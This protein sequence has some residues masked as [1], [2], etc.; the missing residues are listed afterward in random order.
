MQVFQSILVP[1]DGSVRAEQAIP[2]AARVA[3]ASGG[4]ITLLRV[5]SSTELLPYIFGALEPS[6]YSADV[7]T[8]NVYLQ[9]VAQGADLAD[10]TVRTEV[11]TGLAASMILERARANHADL[12]VMTSHGHSGLV[13]WALGSVASKVAR[14]SEEP[15]LVIREEA[16]LPAAPPADSPL[17]AL[18]ALDGSPTAEA[19]LVPAMQLIG[20]MAGSA[21][22]QLHLLHVVPPSAVQNRKEAAFE[23]AKE[24]L[25]KVTDQLKTGL[26]PAS[27]FT[28][29]WSVVQNDDVAEAVM[30][31]A[32][33]G[34]DTEGSGPPARCAFI[35]L[36][37][38]GQGAA[39]HNTLGSV[40]ERTLNDSRL[41][42]LVVHSPVAETA[43]TA[44]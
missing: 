38:H 10:I 21:P 13:R 30:S 4:T 22:S 39:G 42:L 37:T 19:S 36:T 32:N 3:R 8:S 35:A 9:A 31:V 34:E 25:R 26:T 17:I 12:V 40:A 24:Y 1:L 23:T 14:Q 20:A 29:T 27:P 6:T 43:S 2:V 11:H 15:V 5:L 33:G 7:E 16:S 41:P 44:E 18:V 28:V